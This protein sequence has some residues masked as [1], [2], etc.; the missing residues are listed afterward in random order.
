MYGTGQVRLQDQVNVDLTGYKVKIRKGDL[1]PGYYQ[2]GML[3][4]DK[5][6]HLK[7]VNW[8]PNILNVKK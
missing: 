3:A 5:T 2:I 1:V 4:V 7:L 8:V 6:S